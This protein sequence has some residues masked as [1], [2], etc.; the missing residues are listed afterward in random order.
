[1][2]KCFWLSFLHEFEVMCMAEAVS[3]KSVA[4]GRLKLGYCVIRVNSRIAATAYDNTTNVVI[5]IIIIIV[6]V[7]LHVTVS[8]VCCVLFFIMC[9][10]FVPMFSLFLEWLSVMHVIA[11]S[12]DCWVHLNLLDRGVMN[13]SGNILLYGSITNEHIVRSKHHLKQWPLSWSKSLV[14]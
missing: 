4:A 13:T 6:T 8:F 9:R 1:M 12:T 7:I 10:S 11:W 2:A 5:C 3:I 14:K